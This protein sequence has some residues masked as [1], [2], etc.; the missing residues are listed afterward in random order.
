MPDIKNYDINSKGL[1][2]ADSD[3]SGGITNQP[4]ATLAKTRKNDYSPI[5]KIRSARKR[6]PIVVDVIIAIILA[7]IIGAVAVGGFYA[8]RYFT[9]DYDTVDV[10]YMIILD[11]NSAKNLKNEQ[12][13]CDIDGNTLHFGK[14]KSIGTD[15]NGRQVV[16]IAHTVKYKADEGYSIGEERLAVGR[17]YNLRTENGT[18][19]SGT[20][21]EFL[22]K[23]DSD[24]KGGK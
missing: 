10:E 6:M 8:F 3:K 9:V 23:M 17:S 2:N 12:V 5:K 11:E 4:L 24:A 18:N 13:Y 21:V 1:K 14:I 16:V 7:I 22:D 20:V 19:V 15:G